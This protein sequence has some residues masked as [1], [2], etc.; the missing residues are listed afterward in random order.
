MA[1]PGSSVVALLGRG[2]ALAGV[3]LGGI[4]LIADLHT[5]RRFYNMLRIFRVTSPMSI[6][7]YVLMSFGFWTL[8]AFLLQLVEVATLATICCILASVSGWGMAAY[9]AAL[10]SATSTPLWAAMPRLL[11]VQFAS[12]AVATGAATACLLAIL[13]TPVLELARAFG[14]IA[15]LALITQLVAAVASWRTSTRLSIDGPLQARPWRQLAIGGVG[16]VGIAVPIVLYFMANFAGGVGVL[17]FLASLC[18]LGG[19]LLMRGV[20]L[21]CGNESAKRPMDYFRL[22]RG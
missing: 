22:A 18:V 19:G 5:K 20:V 9:T 11:G 2:I 4:L 6:G 14:N 16:V 12:S 7:T 3:I 15:A 8:A 21:L 13:A 1:V 10:L 17:C